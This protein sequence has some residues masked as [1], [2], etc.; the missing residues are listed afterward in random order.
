MARD[1]TA[2]DRNRRHR[3]LRHARRR[4]AA[5]RRTRDH[6]YEAARLV[7]GHTNTVAVDEPGGPVA[8]DTGFIVF[9]DRNYPNFERCWRSSASPASR[10]HMSF[11]RLRRRAAGSSAPARALG[12][13]SPGPATSSAR[14]FLGMLRDLRRFNREARD[15][16]RD[17]RRPRPRSATWLE[18]PA[19]PS[20]FIERLIVPQASAVWSADPEQMWSFP[21]SFMAEFFDNHGV[22]SLRDRPALADGPRRLAQL[23]RGDHG[24]VGATGCGWRTPVRRIERLPDGV[25]DRGRRLRASGSTRSSSPPTPTRRWRL[26]ADAERGRARDARRDPLPAAT[27]PSSTPTRALMPRRRAAWASWNFHLTDEPARA[28]HRHLLD[29]QPAVA[30][31]RAPTTSSR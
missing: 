27:R 20:Y 17:E 5:P 16:D 8:V 29:E 2:P 24:A 7:G 22:Y 18:R 19:S 31:S 15:A 21:A 3:D 13:S 12:A 9:N 26:L 10:P 1:R 11:S 25:A 6:V 30:A 28:D 14:S 23:R 4:R